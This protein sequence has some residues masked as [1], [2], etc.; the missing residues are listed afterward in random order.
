MASLIA[1]GIIKS[2]WAL[3]IL[4]FTSMYRTVVTTNLLVLILVLWRSSLRFHLCLCLS[5]CR[6]E[7][8]GLV[9]TEF[10]YGTAVPSQRKRTFGSAARIVGLK[11]GFCESC[12]SGAAQKDLNSESYLRLVDSYIKCVVLWQSKF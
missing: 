11:I 4:L 7:N 9:N 8:Q 2:F 12:Y 3:L 1:F 5:L 6:S 10:T